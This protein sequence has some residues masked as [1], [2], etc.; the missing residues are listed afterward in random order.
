MTPIDGR[1]RSLI[2]PLVALALSAGRSPRLVVSLAF[3]AFLEKVFINQFLSLFYVTLSYTQQQVQQSKRV[4]RDS[5]S[6]WR[7]KEDYFST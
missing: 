4:A 3:G 2:G 1:N 5:A 7:P 6:N